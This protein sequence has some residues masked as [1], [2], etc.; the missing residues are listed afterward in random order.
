MASNVTCHQEY[1]RLDAIV[2][3]LLKYYQLFL[4]IFGFMGNLL[5]IIVFWRTK[6]AHSLR[7]SY[8]LI[9]L[10]MSDILFLVLLSFN[11]LELAPQRFN[12]TNPEIVFV[13]DFLN[14]D[15]NAWRCKIKQYLSKL[16]Y[17]YFLSLC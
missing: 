15:T 16:E 3:F 8:Y 14:T 10:A 2:D 4:I 17:G 6:F 12:I 7:T 1:P 13:P 5:T 9:C 11:Y